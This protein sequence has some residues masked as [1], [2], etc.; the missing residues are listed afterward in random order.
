MLAAPNLQPHAA[1]A[2]N[3]KHKKLDF[4]LLITSQRQKNNNN[5]KIVVLEQKSQKKG[6]DKNP[7]RFLTLLPLFF[8]PQSLATCDS[9]AAAC[10]LPLR[11]RPRRV[12]K[13]PFPSP[14]LA[15]TPAIR[16]FQP[17]IRPVHEPRIHRRICWRP[18]A[19]AALSV[20]ERR[21]L[22]RAPVFRSAAASR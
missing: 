12:I 17:P 1:K 9:E 4:S 5:K 22:R 13:S 19:P 16:P 21:G 10:G 15:P 3:P 14:D 7:H 18:P 11:L 2:P 6:T 20:S 8:L